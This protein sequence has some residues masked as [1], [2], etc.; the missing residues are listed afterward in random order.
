MLAVPDRAALAAANDR[1]ALAAISVGG[2]GADGAVCGEDADIDDGGDGPG[3]RNYVRCT[4]LRR[5]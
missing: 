5:A 2:V 4:V 3:E 1:S